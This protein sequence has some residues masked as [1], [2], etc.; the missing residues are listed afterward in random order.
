MFINVILAILVLSI[1]V[2][3]HE[4]GH[5]IIAK[6]NGITVV[7][8]S[9]GFG[10]KL[11]HFKKG[12]TEYCIKLFPFGGACTMLGD[13]FLEM[14]YMQQ[15][16]DDDEEN[17]TKEEKE[18]R[19]RK[20]AFENGYDMSKSFS[21]KSVWARIAVIAA[22]PIFNFILA[23]LCAIVI[24]GV[25]GYDPCDIDA[26]SE[27]SPA[28]IAGLQEGDVITKINGQSVVFFRDYSFYRYFNEAETMKITF[29]RDNQKM[30]TTLTPEH[31]VQKKYQVGI[32]I[33]EDCEI[34]TVYEDMPA[35]SAGIKAGDIIDTIDGKKMETNSMIT[36]AIA[37]SQGDKISI[38]VKRDGKKIDLKVTPKLNEVETYYTG[39]TIYGDRVKVSPID[40][41]KYS[42]AEVG[43]EIKSVVLSLGMMFN[44]KVTVDD[45][46]GPV[47]TVSTMSEIVEE[48]KQ[49]GTLYVILN[50]FNL[51][52]LISANLGIMNLLPIPALDGGR[53]V[54]LI[55]EAVRGKPIKEEHE[56]IVHFIGV[57][58]LAIL[59][60]YIMFKDIIRLF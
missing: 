9:I 39:L 2:I 41:I 58:L 20:L 18:E 53:L 6:A 27:D 60:V 48:S 37:A 38:T 42:F 1:I 36:E 21:S 49:D 44:G 45:L 14:S 11:V 52:A 33:S 40:T 12:E 30:T 24:I 50:L 25:T 10:P 29:V 31:I 34:L 59:M 13:A 26:V 51:A 19:K 5:F 46:M 22:G 15:E 28:S 16:H 7:E 56:G 43:Y 54:F 17:L 8:F 55:I 57:I 23:F 47:G 4:F 3:V 32:T 35:E